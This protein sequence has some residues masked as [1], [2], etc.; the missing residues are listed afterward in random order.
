M[1][2]LH[3]RLIHH[4]IT[5]CIVPRN[6]SYSNVTNYDIFLTWAIATNHK[7]DY[8]SLIF[9]KFLDIMS[10]SSSGLGYGMALTRLF[11]YFD[12]QLDEESDM[13]EL[14]EHEIYSERTFHQM[15][16]HVDNGRWTFNDPNDVEVSE[17][18]E[19]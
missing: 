18:E 7:L 19:E 11:K 12:I 4:V 6:G 16:Y 14:T 5:H 8:A 3:A 17:E 9:D 15:H 2:N 1:Q 13:H 10:H